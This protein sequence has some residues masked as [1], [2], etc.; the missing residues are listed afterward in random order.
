MTTNL[1]WKAV[2]GYEGWYEAT[3]CGRIRRLRSIYNGRGTTREQVKE[4]APLWYRKGYCKIQF[5]S[6]GGTR[7]PSRQYIHRVIYR[8]FH[9]EIPEGLTVN[10]KDGTHDNNHADNLELCTHQEQH[11]HA[12]TLSLAKDMNGKPHH[13]TAADVLAIRAEVAAAMAKPTRRGTPRKRALVMT[14]IARRYGVADGTIGYI[15]KRQTWK[16]I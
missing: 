5:N 1:E 3:R 9:G 6:C 4:L 15:V 14:D 12:R 10:H 7:E 11:T 8:T 13:L 2:P 16:H